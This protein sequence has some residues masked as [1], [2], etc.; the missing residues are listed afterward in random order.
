M[1]L[2]Q[3]NETLKIYGLISPID[4]KVVYVG[5]TTKELSF[6]LKQHYWHLNEAIKGRRKMNKR[7]KYLN[8]I[9][10]LK[11]SIKCL[12]V[13]NDVNG[14][15][16]YESRYIKKYREINPDLLN[17]TDGGVG[18]YTSSYKNDYEK[19][20]IGTKISNALKGK[21][22]PDGFAENLSEQRKGLGNPGCKKLEEP[23][24]AVNIE[25]QRRVN[26]KFEYGF[27]VNAFVHKHN[28]WSNVKKAINHISTRNGF[29]G[30]FQQC[31]GYWWLTWDCAQRYLEEV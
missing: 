2:I 25:T 18:Q 31:Y 30:Q 22:K 27:E 6:R 8:S 11:V 10:P 4:G 12:Y 15:K 1:K 14:L 28:A 26:K 20:E 24:Y 7:F 5:A 19:V 29:K 9:L 17:E 13:T 23:I 16:W 3:S 21:S